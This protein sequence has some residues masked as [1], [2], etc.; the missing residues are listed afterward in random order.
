MDT[1]EFLL[2]VEELDQEQDWWEEEEEEED[3]CELIS[4]LALWP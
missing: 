3:V 4:V 1:A 2:A